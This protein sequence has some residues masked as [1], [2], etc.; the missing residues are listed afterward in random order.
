MAI[1]AERLSHLLLDLELVESDDVQ[2]VWQEL[3]RRDVTAQD[4]L[5]AFIRRNLLTN[6]QV[7]RLLRGDRR[8]YFYGPYKVLYLVGAGTF[9]RVYRAVHKKTGQ[10]VALKV[11]R[12]RYS[13]DPIKT[14]QFLR[15]GRMGLKLRHPN[16]VP[17]LEVDNL[18]G[19]FWIVMEFVEGQNLRDLVKVRRR[20]SP[21]DST[22]LMIDVTN[23]IRYAHQ[24]GIMHRDLKPSNVLV[25]SRGVAKV[26]DFGLASQ[27]DQEEGKNLRTVDYAGLEKAS[28]AK[29]NDPRSDIYFLGTIYYYMLSGKHALKE[30]RDRGERMSKQR[31]LNVVPI[32]HLVPDLPPGVVAI[33]NRSLELNP[34]R[35]YQTPSEMLVELKGVLPRLEASQ[36]P[37]VGKNE[38]QTD[39]A[40]AS[41]SRGSKWTVM[42]VEANPEM[43]DA[44]RKGFKSVGYRVLITVDPNRAMDRFLDDHEV[45]DAVVFDAETVG[46]Q[47]LQGFNRFYEEELTRTV[48]CLLLLGKSQKDWAKH[49]RLAPHRVALQLPLTVKQLRVAVSQLIARRPQPV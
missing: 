30:T 42:F 6:W 44:I 8:G 10:V 18:R 36:L 49:A 26:V 40:A 29:R 34:E 2:A 14:E 28:G 25:S 23:A 45:A 19:R 22:R 21:G 3:G 24:K 31:F 5:K 1:S 32:Q 43:Q 11:L 48:P 35:R 16:I 37:A 12:S 17:I 41:V 13:E 46:E 4:F 20:L 27:L 47:A 7:E 39:P 33:C 15:E 9:A 38:S